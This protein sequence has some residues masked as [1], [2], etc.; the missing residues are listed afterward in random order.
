MV[1]EKM[2]ATSGN[3]KSKSS[4]YFIDH[5][6]AFFKKMN[7]I[8]RR[9]FLDKFGKGLVVSPLL[10]GGFAPCSEGET[11]A[12]YPPA[13]KKSL[14]LAGKNSGEL[15]KALSY[16]KEG[17][18]HEAMNFLVG[19]TGRR[20]YLHFPDR[21]WRSDLVHGGA[22]PSLDAQVIQAQDL[23]DNVEWVFYA[24]NT[25]PWAREMYDRDKKS[26]FSRVL[27]YRI[28]TGPLRQLGDIDAHGRSFFLHEPTYLKMKERH[29]L[30]TSFDELRGT[31][32]KYA[33]DYRKAQDDREKGEVIKHIIAYFNV[34]FFHRAE[35]CQY[36]PRGPEEL[37]LDTLLTKGGNQD[38][39][40]RG[41]RCTD[42]DNALRYALMAV[43]IPTSATRFIA[44]PDGDSNHEVVSWDIFGERFD[45]T[46]MVHESTLEC[47]QGY[48]PGSVAKAY[49]EEWGNWGEA[50]RL[51]A[52]R[53][54]GDLFPWYIEFYLGT[55]SMIDVTR[56]YTPVRDLRFEGITPSQLLFLG[57]MNNDSD[58][59]RFGLATVAVSRSQFP[60]DVLFKDVGYGK[61]LLYFAYSHASHD[62]REDG[63]FPALFIDRPFLLTKQGEKI[64]FNDEVK[65]E[66][67]YTLSVGTEDGLSFDVRRKYSFMTFES[68][69]FDSDVKG[70]PAAQWKTKEITACDAGGSVLLRDIQDGVLYSLYDEQ[71]AKFSRPFAF[72]NQKL[73]KY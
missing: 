7:Q 35:A 55:R 17:E 69:K 72:Q 71:E 38:G 67:S 26:F 34:D 27:P 23:I 33:E 10:F 24:R 21:Q 53:N 63:K 64:D 13:V 42:L 60:G 51:V 14:K 25:F 19:E 9:K 40:K 32:E 48:R 65:K 37:S 50:S 41:G 29:R 44:W 70:Y 12:T 3:F 18:K 36:F 46:A 43:G 22:L 52:E 20:M 54:S 11:L 58:I 66:E 2:G 16:F 28:G 6:G 57:V 5:F 45:L 73:L 47:L 1:E 30:S 15:E 39:N 61:D 59:S 31:L 8:S 56:H 62:A 68:G 4:L 49:E